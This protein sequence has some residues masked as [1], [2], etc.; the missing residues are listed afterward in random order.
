MKQF[1]LTKRIIMNKSIF[2]T[3]I[4]A[5]IWVFS[6]CGNTSGGG[7]SKNETTSLQTEQDKDGMKNHEDDLLSFQYPSEWEL[8]NVLLQS[9]GLKGATSYRLK[10]QGSDHDFFW[11][12][13][14]E[15]PS[16]N[17]FRENLDAFVDLMNQEKHEIL[18]KENIETKSGVKGY[19]FEMKKG[20][21]Y[22][23]CV[24]LPAD[25]NSAGYALDGN[26]FMSAADYEQTV[27]NG[28]LLAALQS[29]DIK[30]K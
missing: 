15:A 17:L 26:F 23:A 29:L 6:S 25:A 27:E 10:T 2:T 9:S 4:I 18:R 20:D 24:S 11:F 3:I 16:F 13:I 1:F 19:Y 21:E 28:K 14:D 12:S 5:S 8:N 7:V 22:V 30:V